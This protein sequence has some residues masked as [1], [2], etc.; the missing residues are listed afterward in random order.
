MPNLK[1]DKTGLILAAGYGSRLAGVSPVTSFKPLTPVKGRPLIFRTIKSLETAGCTKIVIVLG[2]GHDEI[3]KAILD[4]Y[5][6]ETPLN[7]VFNEQYKLSNGVSVL[8][9]KELL[10]KRFIMTMADHILGNSLMHLAKNVNLEDG[11]AALLV[12]YK[13]DSIFDMDDAT[14]VLSKA[15]KIVSIGKQISEFNC[16]DTGLFVCSDGLITALQKHYNEYGDT[17]ISDGVQDL[18]KAGKMY[19]VDIEDGVWQDV[20][21][22]EMLAEAERLL[23]D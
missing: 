18:A 10:G 1:V 7:F 13:L 5:K 19:T 11:T 2:Y 20:D 15:G 4:I 16:V 9:A 22:P 21:T 3:K 23:E 14:K 8:S 12:D 17:S 6:G